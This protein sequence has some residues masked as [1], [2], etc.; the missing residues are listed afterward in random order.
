VEPEVTSRALMRLSVDGKPAGN[1]AASCPGAGTIVIGLYGKTVP[2]TVANFEA[3]VMGDTDGGYSYK[4]TTFYKVVQGLN[5]QAGAV[6]DFSGKGLT[7][8]SAKKEPFGPE[9]FEVRHGAEGMVSMVR[10]PDTKNDSRFFITIK[11]DAGWADGRYVAFGRVLEGLDALRG[12]DQLKVQTP[13]NRPLK[14][15]VI[16]ECVMLPAPDAA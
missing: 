5:M 13:S 14:P 4:G 2:E 16:E 10:G 11:P 8:L 9:N 12:I 7:G 6:G 3:L 1:T 15:V